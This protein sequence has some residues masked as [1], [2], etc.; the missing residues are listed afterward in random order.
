MKEKRVYAI[1][2]TQTASVDRLC[3]HTCRCKMVL[4]MRATAATVAAAAIA[5]LMEVFCSG[6]PRVIHQ[7]LHPYIQQSSTRVGV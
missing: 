4:D 2:N 7:L 1:S 5:V 3:I 6:E